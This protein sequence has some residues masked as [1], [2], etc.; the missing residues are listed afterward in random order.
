[1]ICGIRAKLL[2]LGLIRRTNCAR[3]PGGLPCQSSPFH[4]S[5]RVAGSA[6]ASSA[7][8]LLAEL[9]GCWPM[10]A[11]RCPGPDHR[12]AQL[13]ARFHLF[14][15]H[16][17]VVR[18][19]PLMPSR[20]YVQRDGLRSRMRAQRRLRL[21]GGPWVFM[22]RRALGVT[23]ATELDGA[24][25]CVETGQAVGGGRGRVLQGQWHEL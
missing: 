5:S 18:A 15:R 10:M 4:L 2:P 21:A 25:I 12:G 3:E 19:G 11:T 22:I 17:R 14:R 6:C 23:K 24:A 20:I 13:S 8:A 16:M 9:L 7:G 1:V